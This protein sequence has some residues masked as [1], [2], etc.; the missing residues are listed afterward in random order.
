MIHGSPSSRWRL[1]AAPHQ[2]SAPERPH[3]HAEVPHGVEHGAEVV[4]S[5]APR[6][7]SSPHLARVGRDHFDRVACH[8]AYGDDGQVFRVCREKPSGPLTAPLRHLEAGGRGHRP[9]RRQ[10]LC[11][12]DVVET[13]A[14]HSFQ[15]RRRPRGQAVVVR[16]IRH[17]AVRD[18]DVRRGQQ[19]PNHELPAQPDLTD[20]GDYPSKPPGTTV[21][22]ISF[23][24]RT[25]SA[26]A[27][28][29]NLW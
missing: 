27:T 15:Y 4:P 1:A 14:E 23:S 17:F 16:L 25:R 10:R 6:Q 22:R 24:I 19:A 11:T 13:P 28:W 20:L 21:S 8:A 26:R 5:L 7:D 12:Q 2:S 18:G 3:D 29:H 9:W